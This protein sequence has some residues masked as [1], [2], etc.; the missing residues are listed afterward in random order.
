MDYFVSGWGTGGTISGA[1]S[2]IKL[3]RPD[4][5][6]VCV[7]PEKAQLI[8][9]G[10]KAFNS[11]AIQGWTPDFLPETLNQEC[12]DI[13]TSVTDE[14]SINGSKLLAKEEGILTGISGGATFAAALNVAKKA[15]KGSVILAMLPD[16][17]ERYMSTVLFKDIT[18]ESDEV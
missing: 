11:H 1:S 13:L 15:P 2:V 8:E 9:N 6:I 14:E 4:V 16:T 18:A 10:A 5:R 7:E 12:F 17:G 3:A